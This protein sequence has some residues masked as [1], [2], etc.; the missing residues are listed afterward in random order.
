MSFGATYHPSKPEFPQEIDD[1]CAF[2]WTN[3]LCK[4]ISALQKLYM[5]SL[6]VLDMDDRQAQLVG[7]EVSLWGCICFYMGK[8]CKL[9]VVLFL[10]GQ[11]IL[12]QLWPWFWLCHE[13]DWLS[14]FYLTPTDR[15][16]VQPFFVSDCKKSKSRP[17]P[18]H[19]LLY[20]W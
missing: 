3:L 5:S 14:I 4:H 12:V 20:S 8:V 1:V 13:T 15:F 11:W 9:K 18:N 10:Q 17:W 7:Y 6:K 16:F 19:F 2:L